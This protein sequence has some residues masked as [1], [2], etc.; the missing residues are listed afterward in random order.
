MP[1]LDIAG[2]RFHVALDGPEGAPALMLSNSLA[3]NLGMWDLQVPELAKHFRVVRYDSRGHGQSAAPDR[4]Y[5]IAELGRDALAILQ[6]L[7]ISKAHWCGLSKGGMVGQWLATNAPERFDRVIL[8]NTSS[9]MGPPDV[10]NTRIATARKGGMAA[11]ADTTIERWFTAGFRGRAADAVAKVKAMILA[12][13]VQGYAAC[14]AAIR[15]M[16]QRESVRGIKRPVLVI[17]GKVDPGTTPEMG[18]QLTAS[19]PGAKSVTLDAAH[20]SNV[21]QSAAFTKAVVDFLKG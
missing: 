7:N 4:P 13:P 5:S 3:S 10:W 6:A 15:D 2:E 16:D 14:C 18:E 1:F 19:I 9:H 12:T 11:I 8:A 21:E 17:I 20:F